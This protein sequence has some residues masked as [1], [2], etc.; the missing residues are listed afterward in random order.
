M[1]NNRGSVLRVLETLSAEVE[2][3]QNCELSMTRQ[4]TIFAAGN[5]SAELVVVS[6]GPEQE[7]DEKG[8]LLVGR[9][10]R[11]LE[12]MLETIG[13]TRANV[14]FMNVVKCRA[15]DPK[16]DDQ[17]EALYGGRLINR[18]PDQDE[19]DACHPFFV[20]QLQALP[21]MKMILAVG[22]TAGSTV[23]GAKLGEYKMSGMRRRVFRTQILDATAFLPNGPAVV[24]TYAPTYLL[25]KGN[26]G[27][28]V[29]VYGDLKL[30]KDFFAG[31]V[32]TFHEAYEAEHHTPMYG[33]KSDDRPWGK[34]L[35]SQM[36]KYSE[37]LEVV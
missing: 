16:E 30:V 14:Y 10:A 1:K 13:F 35:P 20:A 8:T 7:E 37:K 15:C 6:S 33:R 17:G 22:A 24:V 29:K 25:R 18:Q 5:P 12:R 27:E 36:D 28:K 9:G 32:E 34:L 3:C 31:K 11:I 19:I 2:S 21:N 23:L 26:E 4:K